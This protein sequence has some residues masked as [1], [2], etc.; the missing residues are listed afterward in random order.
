MKVKFDLL[1][2]ESCVF[3]VSPAEK[4]SLLYLT[5]YDVLKM[6]SIVRYTTYLQITNDNLG[7]CILNQ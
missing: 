5:Q 6:F 2:P 3:C 4:K 7:N 1:L